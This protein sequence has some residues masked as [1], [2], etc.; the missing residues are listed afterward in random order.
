MS[1]SVLSP[2]KIN[3]ILKVYDRRPDGYHDIYSLFW[4]KI[5]AERLTIFT[6]CAEITADIIDVEGAVISGENILTKVLKTARERGLFIPPLKIRL[7]KHFPAG[8]GIGAGSGNAAALIKWLGTEYGLAL[9]CG[10]IAKLG[11]DVAFMTTDHSIAAARGAG[12]LLSQATAE[13]KYTWL[14]V[15][16]TW[17]SNTAE[18]YRKL[19][20]ARCG[21]SASMVADDAR[22][23][24]AVLRRLLAGECAGRLPNDFFDV[25][26]AEHAEYLLAEQT[27]QESGASAWGLCGSGSAFFALYADRGAAEAAAQI[28]NK[29]QWVI[30]TYIDTE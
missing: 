8:S 5:A 1:C 21:A 11:A 25:L 17:Q 16:P 12:E 30:K 2:I 24:E 9:S 20:E 18:A 26:A 4:Q 23:E 3:L 19:D 29:M 28:F 6:N 10:E 13:L 14:L 7:E 22:L 15:F 27:V